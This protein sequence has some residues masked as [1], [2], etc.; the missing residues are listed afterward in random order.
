[1]G[2]A[3]PALW[4]PVLAIAHV[5]AIYFLV[6]VL[7]LVHPALSGRALLRKRGPSDRTERLAVPHGSV[8]RDIHSGPAPGASYA[9]DRSLTLTTRPRKNVALAWSDI[10]CS[11][12]TQAGCKTVLKVNEGSRCIDPPMAYSPTS[13]FSTTTM[14]GS[15]IGVMS[16]HLSAIVLVT[17]ATPFMQN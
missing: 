17:H 8:A 16:L 3:H 14:Q 6:K 10:S 4:V 15:C 2:T 5:L 12:V 11:Y 1:M 13:S 7:L 9:A